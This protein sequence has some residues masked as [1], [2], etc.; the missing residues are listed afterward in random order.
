M[1]DLDLH[2]GVDITC[3]AGATMRLGQY[4]YMLALVLELRHYSKEDIL[5]RIRLDDHASKDGDTYIQATRPGRRI[6]GKFVVG[7]HTIGWIRE[8]AANHLTLTLAANRPTNS[9]TV[10]KEEEH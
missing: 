10:V 3:E 2:S 8:T 9:I 4:L 5:E 6:W 7:G 1:E